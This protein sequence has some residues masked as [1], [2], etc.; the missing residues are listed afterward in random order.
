MAMTRAVSVARS[1]SERG[2]LL[3]LIL[4]LGAPWAPQAEAQPV[5]QDAAHWRTFAAALEPNSTV[6]VR[7]TDGHTVRGRLLA[8]TAEDLVIHVNRA[9]FRRR[10]DRRI[11][12]DAI[13]KL[14]KGHPARDFA[15]AT[16]VTAGLGT[17]LIVWWLNGAYSN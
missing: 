1:T 6:A 12:F 2:I 17:L 16:A 3:A 10:L 15:I 4:S 9:S 13:T 11:R 7:L 8:T 5:P 14:S